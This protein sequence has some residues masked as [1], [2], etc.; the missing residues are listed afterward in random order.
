ML[1]NVNQGAVDEF[2]SY[3][4]RVNAAVVTSMQVVALA[5]SHPYDAEEFTHRSPVQGGSCGSAV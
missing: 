4:H 5:L 1:L 3:R 2:R